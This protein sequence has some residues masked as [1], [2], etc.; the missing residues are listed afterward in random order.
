MADNT[1][2]V[3]GGAAGGVFGDRL[4]DTGGFG[5]PMPSSLPPM[6]DTPASPDAT[7][8]M[9]GLSGIDPNL[10]ID[11]TDRDPS[12]PVDMAPTNPFP[13]APPA[14][15]G[16]E[17][18]TGAPMT[19]SFDGQPMAQAGAIGGVGAMGAPSDARQA[20]RDM[21]RDPF[22]APP[23]GGDLPGAQ[24]RGGPVGVGGMTA[25]ARPK[26][27][28][29]SGRLQDTEFKLAD[30]RRKQKPKEPNKLLLLLAAAL[31]VMAGV[32]AAY[33]LTQGGDDGDGGQAVDG[34]ETTVATGES[35]VTTAPVVEE[36]VP[37]EP[38]QAEPTL[39]FDAAQA[40]PLVQGQEYSIDLVGEPPEALLQVVVDGLPQGEP[41]SQLPDLI[42]PAGRHSLYIQITNGAESFTSSQVEIYVTG[43]PPPVGY[44]A[45]LYS[46]NMQTEG[47]GE[48]IRLFDEFRTAGHENLMMV[49]LVDGFWNIFVPGFGE[50]MDAALAYCESFGLVVPD[51]CFAPY[52]DGS[53]INT[54]PTPVA[55]ADGA[56]DG[57]TETTV[58]AEGTTDTSAA[59]PED[60][61]VTTAAGG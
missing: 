53:P 45:N 46:V 16:R 32:V 31:V 8:V 36:T 44:R 35:T 42:L 24:R 54:T 48:A 4:G 23:G 58:A 47:W 22:A 2:V 41:A 30:K 17:I 6:D 20:G 33:F 50:D 27:G 18:D 1:V 38:L 21:S 34:T 57:T 3:P 10:D 51:K 28:G 26:R 15:S 40:G 5:T 55:P 61:T 25:G 60:T 9:P 14:P 29:E 39:V 19:Q 12:G 52:Y 11:L 56:E 43:D 49:S 7:G 37:A 13:D 59:A